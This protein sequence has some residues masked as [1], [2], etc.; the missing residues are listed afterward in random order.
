MKFDIPFTAGRYPDC[1]SPKRDHIVSTASWRRTSV[2]AGDGRFRKVDPSPYEYVLL[3]LTGITAVTGALA[4]TQIH[5]YQ[6]RDAIRIA[7]KAI[8][9]LKKNTVRLLSLLT[10]LEALATA[11]AVT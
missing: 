3:G 6:R 9:N 5:L 11:T 7:R 4:V 10:R 1:W 2:R 8:Q